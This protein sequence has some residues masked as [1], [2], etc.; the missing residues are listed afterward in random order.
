MSKVKQLVAV[1]ILSSLALLSGCE[2][3]RGGVSNRGSSG[4]IHQH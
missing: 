1:L 3:T 4:H 2:S